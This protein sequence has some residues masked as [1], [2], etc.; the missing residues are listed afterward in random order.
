[1]LKGQKKETPLVKR[2]TS[3]NLTDDARRLLKALA[4]KNGV[5]MQSWLEMT[6]RQEAKRE[7][8]E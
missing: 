4:D 7:G 1:M 3:F 6:I 5:P 2:A 8:V